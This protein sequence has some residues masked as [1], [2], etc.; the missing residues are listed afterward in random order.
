[1]TRLLFWLCLFGCVAALSGSIS[2]RS[3]AQTNAPNIQLEPFLSGLQAPVFLTSA[4]D[5]TNRLFLL[6]Q[7]GR[8]R[9]KQ[10]NANTTTVYLDIT[11][12]VLAGGERGLIGLAFHPNFASNR[13]FYVNY[14]RRNDGATV[15]AEY[16]AS[17]SNA[18][19]ADA[20]EK[21]LLTIAQ[22]F[23]NHNGG[24]LAFGQDGFL[25]I[26]VGDGG[27]ANDPGNRAQNIEELL[28]KI[29]RIDVDTP[30]GAVPYSAPADNPYF[31][32]TSGRDE[33]Y[34]LG[35]RNP[36]RFSFDRLTGELYVGDVGQGVIEEVDIVKR[37]G[38]Y[39]WRVLEGTRCTNLGPGS[40]TDTKFMPPI[41]QYQ[42]VGNACSG[43][44]TGG[45]V[46][47]GT[48]GTLTPGTYVFADYCFGTI[49]ALE[50]GNARMLL[51]TSLGFTSFGEDEAGE[52][53]VCASNG[54]IYR[55]LNTATRALA[56]VSA[57]SYNGAS[58]A[59]ESIVAAFGTGL[60]TG[61][62]SATATLPTA[63]LETR[64]NVRDVQGVE[65][66]APLF[67]VSPG[68]VNYLLP[69]G[70]ATGQAQIQ[71]TSGSGTLSTQSINV[72][73]VAP[74]IF[75]L[76]ASG[77]GL[78]AALALRVGL[79]GQSTEPVARFDPVTN[80]YVAL[81]I[82]L[83]PVPEPVYLVVF[84]TGFRFASALSAVSATIG[85]ENAPVSFAGAQGQLVGLDQANI[86]IP[87]SLAGRGDVDVIL[88]V[89]GQETNT[90]RVNI[91]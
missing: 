4:R 19:L 47:R 87:R 16:R 34:A 31:G 54:V 79:S 52:L 65:R 37:G 85:G 38:N 39:G 68:Q 91:Q 23:E 72:T 88:R 58:L 33:I 12:K 35:L 32:A 28:G 55:L 50:N 90:V 1:M 60:A 36:W 66:L 8:I 41:Y 84:G 73:P 13:R 89:D 3:H 53:Y 30:N 6:E 82:D 46:Y 49:V 80:Q 29:L 21:V 74:A 45:Y 40:C 70:T 61:T 27:S 64:V 10:P 42:H 17:L 2:E 20:D 71:I 59:P 11:A 5:T 57:A 48:A 69:A 44:I 15:I 83:G 77:R 67:F 26:G 78:P 14:T 18:N 76:N 62:Q 75:T 7:A 51:D 24:M 63:L 9:V 81:P 43:S 56:N 22:P 86:S 25:Y